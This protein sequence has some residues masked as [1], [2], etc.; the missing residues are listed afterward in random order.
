V[1]VQAQGRGCG[2]SHGVWDDQLE[3]CTGAAGAGTGRVIGRMASTFDP[4]LLPPL[5]R[6][7]LFQRRARRVLPQY[8]TP[9][10]HPLWPL[11]AIAL[12]L[13]GVVLSMYTGLLVSIGGTLALQFVGYP[14]AIFV[15]L[16]LWLLPDVDRPDRPPFMKLLTV[17]L[18]MMMWPAYLSV[19]LPGLPWITPPRVVLAIML[20]VMMVH[21]PQNGQTRR[22]VAALL[23]W[24]RP[25]FHLYMAYLGL[26]L[27]L[28]PFSRSP[29]ST[30]TYMA[31]QETLALAPMVLAACALSTDTAAVGKAVRAITIVAALTMAIGVLENEMQIPPWANYIPNWLAMAPEMVEV[32]LSPQAR[33]G[34]NRYRVR[35]VFAV[36]LYYTQYL[37]LVMPLIFYAAWRAKG[38]WR[39]LSFILIPLLLHTVW[40]TNARTSFIGMFI[41]LF[42]IMGLVILRNV[43]FRTKGDG[44]GRNLIIVGVFVAMLATAGAI[45][46]SH[47]LKMYTFG[48]AQHNASNV[49]RDLQWSNAWSQLR[50][51]PV[52]VGLGNSTYYAG[53]PKGPGILI[54]DSLWIN[55]LV[56]LGIIGFSLYFGFFMRVAWVGIFTFLRADSEEEEVAGIL[57]LGLICYVIVAYVVS[58]TDNGY[59]AMLESV[60]ILT[61]AR[62]QQRRLSGEQQQPMLPGPAPG[63]AVAL[64]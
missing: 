18:F 3:V 23:T 42:G 37:N 47:R 63:M 48:G 58:N 27:V 33:V 19:V 10:Y 36:V 56:D 32:A 44:F 8:F 64:R 60:A 51:N 41:G 22:D 38:K 31:F 1:Y 12:F 20:I 59:I 53:V 30:I 17:Y 21:L 25:A 43:F 50:K 2:L 11:A 35:T 9:E 61:L 52:G 14:I 39:F 7:T 15:V 34:D 45:M 40:Y 49:A 26:A 5:A 62:Q 46:S 57:A 16:V 29:S 4:A 55:F 13:I 6:R 54:L 28:V 24:D